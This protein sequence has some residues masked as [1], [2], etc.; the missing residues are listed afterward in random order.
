MFP[1]LLQIPVH[2]TSG[3]LAV[4]VALNYCNVVHIAGFGYP[5]SK[6]QQQPIHY[7]GYNTMKSM[8]NS[9]HDLNHEAEALKR[10]EDSGAILYLHPH[11]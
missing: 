2:P 9:Y 7:Y 11:I 5:S 8:K 3:I 10:L 4:F 6:N 1:S